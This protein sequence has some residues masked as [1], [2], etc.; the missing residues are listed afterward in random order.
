M[1]SAVDQHLINIWV[2]EDKELVD[3]TRWPQREPAA[4]A[5]RS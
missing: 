4:S 1:G 5:V 3:L 2:L